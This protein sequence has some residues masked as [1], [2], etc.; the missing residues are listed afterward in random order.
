MKKTNTYYYLIPFAVLYFFFN[1]LLLPEGLLYTALLTPM[2]VYYIYREGDFKQMVLW[3]VLFLIPI[4]FHLIHGVDIRSFIISTTLVFTVVVFFF[5]AR[6]MIFQANENIERIFRTILFANGAL[7]IFA[8]LTLPAGFLREIF[9]YEIPI[10]VGVQ[11]FPRLKLLAY[12][13]SHY[14]LLLS[15]VFFFYILK[16]FTGQTLHP[17]ILL[18]A[19]FLPLMLSLSFGVIASMVIALLIASLVYIHKLSRTYWSY[20]FYSSGFVIIITFLIWFLWPDNPVYERIS[21]ILSGEDTSARG[22]LFNSF[23][24][25]FD[26]IKENNLWLG[27]G[28]G[29]IKILAHDMIVNYYKYTGNY[30]EIVRIPNSMGEMLA[31]YGLIGFTLKLVLEFYFFFRLKICN[32]FYTLVLFLFIF[33]YQFTGSFLV[34]VAEIGIWAIVFTIKLPRFDSDNLKGGT[35]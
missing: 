10:S 19:V 8:M 21:N 24:F 31:I 35:P 25:A 3:S 11:G 2:L 23:W 28:P 1:N 26:L 7:I 29:Q 20:I 30:A 4:P 18:A 27:V 13:P 12:E 6:L 33:I 32:N 17:L 16:V 15:P 34:N 5:A 9:W 22:R 14:A